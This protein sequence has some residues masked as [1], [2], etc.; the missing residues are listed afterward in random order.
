MS[1][2]RPVLLSNV[3]PALFV[4]LVGGAA[5]AQ[6]PAPWP[7]ALWNP[8]PMEDD[9]VLPLPCGGAM[10]FRRI[11]VPAKD[12]L[13]DRRVTLGSP[14]ARFAW[15]ENSR[16]DWV[17]GGFT[18]AAAPGRRFFWLGKYEVTRGQVAALAGACQ[19]PTAEARLPKVEVTWAESMA[20]AAT[21]SG[22][23]ATAAADR[24]PKEEGAPGFL[25][26]P[27]EAEW[28]YAARGGSAVSESDF[29]QPAFPMTDG[30]ARYVWHNAADSANNE[31]NAIGLLKPNPLGLFDILGNAGEFVLDPFRLNKISRLHGQAGGFTVKGG[32][33]RTRAAD[34]RSA[35]R[36]EFVPVDAKGERRSPGTGFRLALVAPGLPSRQHLETVRKEWADLSS[37][38]GTA[39]AAPQDDPVKEVEVLVAAVEEPDLKRRV[40]NLATVIKASIQ[41]RN[42]QRDRAARSAARVGTY[43]ARQLADGK[44]LVEFKEKQIAAL[45]G[46]NQSVRDSIAKSLEG[47]RK[48]LDFNLNYYLDTLV[49]LVAEYPDDVVGAQGEV[50]KRESEARGLGAINGFTDAFLGHARTLRRDGKLD[51]KKVL[52]EIP[53]S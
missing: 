44:R 36:E 22:W 12:P 21:W 8:Q 41:T 10:A 15:A 4:L 29:A 6:Q 45:S 52:A 30:L 17:A 32:D 39:L 24:L 16:R 27:T 43:L 5:A 46:V 2:R 18:D 51:R 37:S 20:F 9:L 26:L 34:I 38:S 40:Q 25:R 13:D 47:D 28:E 1:D 48:S 11:E 49:Q 31:L 35:A 42:E 3:V 14:E 19:A 50:L 23:L 7:Q 33:Y 53:A